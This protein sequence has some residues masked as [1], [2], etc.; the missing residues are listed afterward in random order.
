MCC[1]HK[2]VPISWLV[3]SSGLQARALWSAFG[4]LLF[5]C[6]WRSCL[7]QGAQCFA[8]GR[9]GAGPDTSCVIAVPL[10]TPAWQPHVFRHP[11]SILASLNNT[12]KIL[13]FSVLIAARSS[14]SCSSHCLWMLPGCKA[15]GIPVGAIFLS[16]KPQFRSCR[17]YKNEHREIGLLPGM[18]VR[19][20]QL[21]LATTTYRSLGME[22][23]W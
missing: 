8:I 18:A 22:F 3:L 19:L 4:K 6:R 1:Y 12:E 11:F 13:C 21:L 17:N 16:T 9:R 14:A 2:P 20:Q 15:M 23:Q 5:L 7:C 10:T